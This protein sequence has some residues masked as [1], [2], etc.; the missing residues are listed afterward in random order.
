MD[1]LTAGRV[2]KT[3]EPIIVSDASADTH[4]C[5]ERDERLGTGP[6]TWPRCP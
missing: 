1:E 3:G 2:I 6:A 5:E 4:L